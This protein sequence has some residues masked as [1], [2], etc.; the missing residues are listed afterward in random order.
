MPNYKVFLNSASA[1]KR[2]VI[3]MSSLWGSNKE[4]T[5]AGA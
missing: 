4:K 5:V 2:L 3:S 1:E